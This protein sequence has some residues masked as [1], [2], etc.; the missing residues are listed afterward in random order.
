MTRIY[1][2]GESL[3]MDEGWSEPEWGKE[4][5]HAQGRVWGSKW[6]VSQAGQGIFPPEKAPLFVRCKGWETEGIGEVVAPAAA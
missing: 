5:I 3:G 6:D 2:R 4:R 1:L